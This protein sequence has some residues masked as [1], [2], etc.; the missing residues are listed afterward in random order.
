MK[1]LFEQTVIDSFRF[2]QD[3]YGFSTPVAEDF[4]REIFVRYRRADQIVSISWEIGSSPITEIFYPSAETGAAP[5]PWA[6]RDGVQRS[7]RF[8]KVRPAT[9]FTNDETSMVKYLEE[10][11]REFEEIE[12]TWLKG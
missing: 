10:S 4:G 12:A 11:A 8:P 7:R 3:K 2:L 1:D 9:R 5:V 6:S